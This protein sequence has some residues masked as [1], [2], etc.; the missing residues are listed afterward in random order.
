M[1]DLRQMRHFVTVCEELHFRRAAERLGMT[2]PPLTQSIQAM[3][4]ELGVAL[5][6]RSRRHV[7]LTKAGELL[8]VE[9]RASL[10]Q[11]DRMMLVA[12]RAKRGEM[13]TLRVGFS[14]SA[15]FVRAFT[16]SV[17]V[18]QRTHPD[19]ALELQRITGP[20]WIALLERRE[21]DLC[22]VRPTYP[23]ALP[24]GLKHLVL[25]RDRLMLLLHANHRLHAAQS[26]PLSAV[27]DEPF[28]LHPPHEATAVYQQ[29]MRL[30]AAAGI[31]PR[32]TQELVDTPTIMGLVA[33]GIGFSILPSMQSVIRIDDVIWRP[34]DVEHA[35]TETGVVLVYPADRRDE[36]PQA[37]FLDLITQF[38]A[39][40]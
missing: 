8:L 12:Q 25:Q 5:L 29:V 9:A 34:I 21:I 4:R 17:H 15:S 38:T 11:A 20:R 3:E 23:I 19:V 10:A 32:V 31:A 7:E 30:W 13:G 33:A 35:L 22:V 24:S 28:I 18:F 16:Q 14:I 1:I 40:V 37:A 2:Q 27:A 26:V 36:M 39:A 6:Q